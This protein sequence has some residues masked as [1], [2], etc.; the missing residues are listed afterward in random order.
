MSGR[1]GNNF[2]HILEAPG[3]VDQYKLFRLSGEERISAPFAFRLTIRSQGDI[4]PAAAW[5]NAPITF[6]LGTSDMAEERRINGRC[7]AFQHLYQKAGYVEFLI[8]V[9]P[10]F[11]NL[12]LT[13]NRRIFTDKSARQVIGT[14]LGEHRVAFDDGKY[15]PSPTRP[16]IVQQDESDFAL[17]SRLMEDEGVFYYFRFDEGAAPYK[18]RMI[19]AGDASGYYDGQPFDL[20]F[21]RD[22]LLRGLKDLQMG[23]ASAPARVVTHDYDFAKPGDLSPVTAPSKLDWAGGGG[24]VYRFAEDYTDPGVGR[25]RAKLRIEGA[26]AGAVTMKGE[27]SYVAFAP[28]ARFQVDDTRLDP[29]ERRIVVRAVN[30]E[31]FDPYGLDEGEPSYKQTF[32]AQ[33]SAQTF[34]PERSTP[35][36]VSR[37]PQ[38][39]V[40][41]D[42]NDP[43]GH[44]R[45]KVKFHWD[46][47]GAST[48]WVRVLQQWAGN[49][50]GAQFVPRPGMEVL[51]DFVE[52]RADR[53]VVVGC[54]YN[55]K[56]AHSYAVPANLTQAG[57]RTFG[58]GGLAHELIFEDKAGS[59]EV[60]MRSGRNFRRDVSNDEFGHV[61]GLQEVTVDKTSRF[62]ATGRI[63]IASA[64]SLMLT[65]GD[66]RVVITK[67]GVWIDA[68]EVNL[69]CDGQPMS[70]APVS[71]PAKAA[72]AA[73][74]VAGGG[75]GGGAGPAGPPGSNQKTATGDP[76]L[77]GGSSGGAGQQASMIPVADQTGAA[78]P[79]IS[80]EERAF[81]R[82]GNRRAF[83]ASR[84]ARGD[85]MARTATEIVDS[86]SARGYTANMRL[87]NGLRSR[88][89]DPF[90][91]Y[92]A[93]VEQVGRELMRE[94]VA[95]TDRFGTLT[96][97]Q[98][99]DY[100]HKVFRDHGLPPTMF[101][102]TMIT[103]NRSEAD[104][105]EQ[106]WMD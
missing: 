91:N 79:P 18:H 62:F 39:A 61:K 95:G 6:S 78:G 20:S 87:R 93:E 53:P 64:E 13:R 66:S 105:Y 12:T 38:T 7:K 34:R 83:W 104:W 67:D 69:N 26:E 74:M 86:S 33:P 27:G 59:E 100:H 29:R 37:G 4:P 5:I 56:N 14:I 94:H 102:G 92:D 71:P 32:E 41:V 77:G 47:A 52:G 10:A 89:L 8:E 75:G 42:Q 23:Y 58:E 80:P 55:G 85:K 65:V 3:A 9:A 68:K 22:H 36:A 63:E 51:V 76:L 101:G 21:R 31:A 28:A 57:F 50:M 48:C 40:V 84:L 54:L 90:N 99:A 60:Y 43:D 70:V 97:P 45:V 19:L 46:V 35:R 106:L 96:P 72:A 15:G 1:D 49:Q 81:A 73:V 16:Y 82:D 2:L 103:G 30:H 25:D 88:D 98:I 24:Q 11:E 17:V 44:G